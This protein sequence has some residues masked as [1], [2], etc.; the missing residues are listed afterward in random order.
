MKRVMIHLFIVALYISGIT[1]Q[2]PAVLPIKT[3]HHKSL[4]TVKIGDLIIPDILLDTGYAFDGLMIYNPDYNDS[5]HFVDAMKVKIPG[6]GSGEP[7]IALMVDSAAFSLGKMALNNQR[8]L[9]MQSNTFKG[10]PSNG[11]IGYS[12][13]GH[14]MT[15]VDY[16]HNIMT[17]H[18]YGQFEPDSSWKP[19]PMYFKNNKIPWIDVSV[20]IDREDPVQLFTY[21][22][23][24]AA[25]VIELLQRNNMKFALPEETV[26]VYL[27]RG[28]SGDIYGQRGQIARLIIGP[29]TMT[30]IEAA[31]APANVRSKQINADAVIGSGALHR[32][33]VIFDYAGKKLYL[34]P[35][36]YFD[37]HGN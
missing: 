25:E 24:A 27:G 22:D 3:L 14:Y 23:F 8:L 20:V 21:I 31:I 16:D 1:D 11:I 17:L 6:A 30:D 5:L 2:G 36:R 28:L 34:K 35:N 10:F 26:D 29:Y 12:I 13:F 19:V 15:E 4:I 7:S 18:E 32:F 9:I 37:D 33:N